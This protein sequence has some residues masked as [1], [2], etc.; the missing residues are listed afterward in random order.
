MKALSLTIVISLL[1]LI[2]AC[3]DL[4]SEDARHLNPMDPD[5]PANENNFHAPTEPADPYPADQSENVSVKPTLSWQSTDQDGDTLIYNIYFGSR[6]QFG[7]NSFPPL[8]PGDILNETYEPDTLQEG[9]TYYWMV[10]VRDNHGHLSK[11][12]PWQ[13]KTESTN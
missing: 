3:E 6:S 9:T 2:F 1:T 4:P 5:N 10:D 8:I 11:G 13:F 12:P 7:N